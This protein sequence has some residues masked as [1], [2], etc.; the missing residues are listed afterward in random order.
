MIGS[1]S[2]KCASLNVNGLSNP[3]KRR[4]V[5]AKMKKDKVQIIFLQETHMSKNEHEKLK[6]LGYLNSFFS[7][8]ENSLKRGV[9]TLISNSLNFELIIKKSDTQVRYVIIKGRIDN[10]LVTFAN[11]YTPPESDRKFCKSLFHTSTSESEGVL[12][13]AGDWNTVLNY[14]MD[15]TSTKRQNW[16]KSRDLNLLIQE[17]GLFD[18]WRNLHASEKDYTHYSATH[19]VHSR[20]D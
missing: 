7:S 16:L 17:T 3:V 12:V 9:A 13:C 5:L 20:I 10:I 6:N 15:T 19:R 4:K 1:H 8:C 11:I 14:S 2:L 18:V